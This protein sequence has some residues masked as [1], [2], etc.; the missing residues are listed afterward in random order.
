MQ[1][2]TPFLWFDSQAEEAAKFYTTVFRNSKLD[3]VVRYGDGGPGPKGTVMVAEFTLDGQQFVALNGGPHYKITPAI[4]FVINCRDQAD[5]DHYWDKLTSDGGQPVQCGWLTDKFGVS[6]Q[7]VPT[8]LNQ[9]MADPDKAKAARVTQ[10][11]MKMVKLD[12]AKLEEAAA[13]AAA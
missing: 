5:V 8:I 11:M 9:L 1:K 13:A 2:I 7:V 4:S 12:V 3:R 6:W 10:A